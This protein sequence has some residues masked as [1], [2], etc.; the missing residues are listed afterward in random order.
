MNENF[1]VEADLKEAVEILFCEEKDVLPIVDVVF[2]ESAGGGLKI[3]RTMSKTGSGCDVLELSFRLEEGPIREDTW[4]TER[5]DFWKGYFGS[6]TGNVSDDRREKDWRCRMQ[7]L[8]SLLEIA[9]AGEK[10]IRIW[11]SDSPHE[12]CGLYHVCWLLRKFDT[13]RITVVK[14]PD[15]V[16]GSGDETVIAYKDWD[17]ADCDFIIAQMEYARPLTEIERLGCVYTW[18]QL[19]SENAGLRGKLNGKLVSLPESF[20]DTLIW[21]KVPEGKFSA[22]ELI[23]KLLDYQFGVSDVF[24][25]RRIRKMV[26]MGMLVEA[27]DKE[28][29]FYFSQMLRKA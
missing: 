13:A 14:M 16:C 22:G 21:S 15:F 1:K 8:Q 17:E 18:K 25:L 3:A 20:Y 12:I 26:E 4:E 6:V 24:Y 19:L 27:D 29:E 7:D 28:P 23:G 5:K 9:E 11:Y 2:G 10:T